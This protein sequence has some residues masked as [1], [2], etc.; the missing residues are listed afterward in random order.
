MFLLFNP[1]QTEGRDDVIG[2]ILGE[3]VTGQVIVYFDYKN[4][5]ETIS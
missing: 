1:L 5:S 2:K 3:G 4:T